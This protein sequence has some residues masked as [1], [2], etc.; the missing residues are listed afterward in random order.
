MHHGVEVVQGILDAGGETVA[1]V[2]EDA[3]ARADLF[4]LQ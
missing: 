3:G 1:F 2:A 4:E